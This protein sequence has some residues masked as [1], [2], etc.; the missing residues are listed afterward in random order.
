MM[1]PENSY[2]PACVS[3]NTRNDKADA[4]RSPGTRHATEQIVMF[5]GPSKKKT[6]FIIPITSVPFVDITTR[7]A[8]LGKLNHNAAGASTPCG[9]TEKDDTAYLAPKKDLPL[10]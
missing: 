1:E 3:G 8:F 6:I 2:L 9:A 5:W 4:G 10:K 7:T